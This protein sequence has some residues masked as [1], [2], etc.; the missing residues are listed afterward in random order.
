MCRDFPFLLCTWPSPLQT[1][2]SVSAIHPPSILAQRRWTNLWWSAEIGKDFASG[3]CV[4]ELGASDIGAL[5]F[6]GNLLLIGSILL[7]IFL[8]HVVVVSG[9]EALWLAKVKASSS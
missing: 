3:E 7:G 1:P 6:V 9:I 4:L 2:V 5:V 8:L